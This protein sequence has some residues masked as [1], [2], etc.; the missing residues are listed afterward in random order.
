MALLLNCRL[1]TER[2][3]GL[4]DAEGHS[5]SLGLAL[6]Y[7]SSASKSV[8]FRYRFS[9]LDLSDPD[10]LCPVLLK[11]IIVD[12]IFIF[13]ELRFDLSKLKDEMYALRL[14]WE[15]VLKA[16][17]PSWFPLVQIARP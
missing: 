9:S 2:G 8:V 3:Q 1:V 14:C 12:S 7:P 16:V 6:G 13:T 4:A 11:C 5:K 15:L 17:H 10:A